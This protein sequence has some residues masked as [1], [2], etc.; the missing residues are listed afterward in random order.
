MVLT[1]VAVAVCAARHHSSG[2]CKGQLNNE[3]GQVYLHNFSRRGWWVGVL[4]ADMVMVLRCPFPCSTHKCAT[5][6]ML[7][8]ST[9]S[10]SRPLWTGS[11]SA[12]QSSVGLGQSHSVGVSHV[13]DELDERTQFVSQAAGS[14]SPVFGRVAFC[15]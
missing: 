10:S 7:P 2:L 8:H 13:G 12:G 15:W 11:M 6:L 1:A 3:R 14:F 4:P 5:L 9:S